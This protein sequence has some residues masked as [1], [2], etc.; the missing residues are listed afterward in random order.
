MYVGILTETDLIFG[1]FF[2]VDDFFLVNHIL[3]LDKH[4]IYRI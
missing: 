2:V 1:K 3:L 4:Y